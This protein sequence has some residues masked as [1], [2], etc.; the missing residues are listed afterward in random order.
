MK[1][2]FSLIL[3]LAMIFTLV[4]I[5][6]NAN[7]VTTSSRVTQLLNS[8]SLRQKI[9]QMLMPDFR[10]WDI[11]GDGS[12]NSDTE[13][14]TQMTDDVR[15]IIED[16]D[17]GAV[18]YFAQNLTGTEQSYYLTMEMQKAA[19]K[20][21][22]IPMLIAADQ[23]GG[24]VYR[25]GT[26]T[27]LPGNMALGAATDTS[28]AKMAGEII[29]RE[30]SSL[31]INT[32]LAPVVDVNNNPNNPVIG[33]RS[34]S[35]DP[36]LVG[37][38][39]SATIA[40]LRESNVIGCAK[41][42]PGHGDTATDS[43]YGL[44]SVD[45]SLSVL[46]ECE[47]KPYEIAIDQGI[48]MIMTAHILYPQLESDT[49]YSNK[50]GSYESLPATMSDD[51]LTDLL[52]GDMGFEGVV[53]TDAMNMEGIAN[54]WDNV[55]ACVLAIQAGV[56]MICMPV[57]MRTSADKS[58]LESIISGIESAVNNGTI[59]MSR[60]NDAVTR[61]LTV[62][63]NR[64][65]LDWNEE[66]YTAAFASYMVGSELNRQAE[67]EIA[68]AAVT[69][70]QNK[71]NV[72]PLNVT[73]STKVVVFVPYED[74]KAQIAMAWNRAKEAGVVPS[75]AS[76]E[77]LE[78]GTSL[79]STDT[80]AISRANI[81]IVNSEVSA[82]S[83]MN[84]ATWAS[85]VPMSIV[86]TAE[87]AGKTTVVMSSDKPYDVQCY[88]NSDAVLAVY[89]CK[90]SSVDPT[91]ALTGSVTSSEAAYGPNI[92]AGMEVMLGVFGAQGKLPLDIPS[93]NGS[94]YTNSVLYAK[95]T[96]ITYNAKHV[97]NLTLVEERDA[98]TQEGY[99][100][101]F[102]QC[103]GCGMWFEDSN[104]K[105]VIKDKF[106]LVD[107]VR[108]D[109][110]VNIEETASF[111]L[112]HYNTLANE[113][114]GT[115][116]S[117]SGFSGGAWNDSYA[118]EPVLGTD[119]YKLVAISRGY[120]NGGTGVLPAVPKGGFV[121]SLNRGNSPYYS[122]NCDNMIARAQEWE[123]GDLFV[124]DGIDLS[125]FSVPTTTSGT[126]WYNSS[127][128]CT[129]TFSKVSI[130]VPPTAEPT[131]YGDAFIIKSNIGDTVNFSDYTVSGL[132]GELT[133]KDS[134]GNEVSQFVPSKNCAVSFTVTDGKTE[135]KVYVLAKGK[136][137]SEYVIF[138]TDFSEYSSISEMNEDGWSFISYGST[139]GASTLENGALNV[140]TTNQN[141]YRVLLPSWIGDFGDYSVTVNAKMGSVVDKTRWFAMMY[142]IQDVG[143]D[144]DYY[145]MCVRQNA[146]AGNGIAFSERI[147][148][149]AWNDILKTNTMYADLSDGYHN[150]NVKAYNK[151][152]QHNI[153]GTEYQ[154][155]DSSVITGT[156]S[157]TSASYLEKGAIGLTAS[158]LS[159]S[160]RKIRITLQE[161]IPCENNLLNYIT[162][163]Q[164]LLLT[165]YQD[166]ITS[167][168]APEN[169]LIDITNSDANGILPN[170]M[171]NNVLPTF[172]VDSNAEVWNIKVAS[173]AQSNKDITLL[174]SNVDVL[175]Y[176]SQCDSSFRRGLVLTKEIIESKTVNELRTLVRG[177][178]ATFCV[179]PV[180]CATKELV[181]ELQEL[182][183]SVWARITSEPNTDAFVVD[184]VKAA[185]AGVNGIISKSASAVNAT[186]NNHFVENAM[187]RTSIMIGH[188]GNPGAGYVGNSMSSFKAAYANGADILEIDVERTL[189]GVPVIAHADTDLVATTTYGST[190][191]TK[192]ISECNLA[193]VQSYNLIDSKGNDIGE[194]IPTLAEVI[195]EFKDK[196]IKIFLEFKN[197]DT[198]V[199]TVGGV[200]MTKQEACVKSAMEIILA[201]SCGAM[202]DVISFEE[203]ALT[204][205]QKYLPGMSTGF[206]CSP[207]KAQWIYP[208]LT[209]DT[210][211][212]Y[213]ASNV[214]LYDG[215]GTKEDNDEMTVAQQYNSTINPSNGDITPK[216]FN[217]ATD[218]GM[219]V[220]PWTYWPA[221]MSTAFLGGCDGITTD[222]VHNVKNA[223]KFVYAEN[224]S[225]DEDSEIVPTIT[226]ETYGGTMNEVVLPDDIIITVVSGDDVVTVEN[227]K[228]VGLKQGS[229]T[230]IFG[231]KTKTW[232][233]KD[234]VLY[235]E[236][237]TVT[238]EA[239]HKENLKFTS[240]G[241]TITDDIATNYKADASILS[242]G[243]TNPYVVFEM[244]GESTTV[245]K[246][247]V[248]ED[249]LVFDF[250]NIAPHQMNDKITA[251]L[252]ASKDGKVRVGETY[253]YSIK[254]YCYNT[255]KNYSDNQK[256]RT[257]IVNL[258]N[259]GAISQ[260]YMDYETDSYV[261][262]DLTDTQE[263]WASSDRTLGTVLNTTYKTIANPTVTWK[264]AGLNL[265]Q[266]VGMRFR[267][268]AA[269]FNGLYVKVESG[270]DVWEIPASK[271]E[272]TENGTYFY[273]EGMSVAQMSDSVYFTVYNGDTAVSNTLCYS[274]ESYAYAKLNHNDKTLVDLVKAM[275]RYGDSA[276]AY[277]G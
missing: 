250:E 47:L 255:L 6:V 108:T 217:E 122:D 154:Y 13:M 74:E 78:Y 43:H 218:R 7:A 118:F 210:T 227:G 101:S 64:G 256:L 8:M 199:I 206:L 125:T 36:D 270:E 41:H 248:V 110:E 201:N 226:A 49:A 245:T 169:V 61:I 232:D 98:I 3:S 173:D 105:T 273:F 126:N 48:D 191:G 146:S 15:Q 11:N 204:Y 274:I 257:L 198:T 114:A 138:E 170:L 44:P 14:F 193:E 23:E 136:Y 220:W 235:T 189:D 153:D 205:T 57:S 39:A 103:T 233:E 184:T 219:S 243:Y 31:G 87:N 116:I 213:K 133:W 175:K 253:E 107:D 222:Y 58:T 102:Y 251:T 70:V 1:R 223:A 93:Y 79:T 135:K 134:S 207:N 71:N 180:E 277:I 149:T 172:E 165:G 16:Y 106:S 157:T 117:T 202:F 38:L 69:V 120:T 197:T 143:V 238:V 177:A 229:A 28:Y 237:V 56:D 171:K 24:M 25:L 104:G 59:P 141:Y 21:G 10:Y 275:M 142:R 55:Q 46:K 67:R 121:Y 94:T 82:S 37:N 231:Y 68:A 17:F 32:N 5:P 60:I 259:Y 53:I 132:E 12:V 215:Y 228:L 163:V 50:T 162:N 80:S 269:S 90:G 52:K 4:V 167:I 9:T 168:D 221:G 119:A 33:L 88:T 249:K 182:C 211:T 147:S 96:G 152:I 261:N 200:S 187:T 244:N 89:G 73:S 271:F 254:T 77:V 72:L 115:V 190:G 75:N 148:N 45:K 265:K 161:T 85:A 83:K 76:L 186:I 42:F 144:N 66:D 51:I 123:I 212:E 178:P 194:P 29:G 54:N 181:Y 124:F 127:Y 239:S 34:Y 246:Y 131:I 99:N 164:H 166:T 258:L 19:T 158:S 267:I 2:I 160:V 185:T 84:G 268:E 159:V 266:S 240:V 276:K 140:N 151:N 95:G 26:G 272:T 214:L 91:E 156:E 92:I 112:T 196:D 179:I 150:Y 130:E 155:I 145:H 247:S 203:E 225:I 174:S 230:I 252:Y 109:L 62:K 86:S 137:E 35:D 22:G 264:A 18:I 97:H 241:L 234:Y 216:Y 30:L 65:I 113:G 260:E 236:A 40:G 188:R 263:S 192:K 183:V 195:E 139:S 242:D 111:W 129:A 81:V 262:E 27:A 100:R 224:I 209:L 176:A 63:E 128:V 208:Y 20:D